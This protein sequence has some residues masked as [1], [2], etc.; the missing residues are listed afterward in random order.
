M[1]MVVSRGVG[2]RTA[3]ALCFAVALLGLGALA[4]WYLHLRFLIQLVPGTV[5][6]QFNTALAFAFLGGA[7]ASLASGRF[8]KWPVVVG[9]SVVAAIG[10]AVI[11]QHLIESPAI[12]TLFFEPWDWDPTLNPA[13]GRTSFAAAMGF[14]LAGIGLCYRAL[15]ADRGF[16]LGIIAAPPLAMAISSLLGQLVGVETL[17]LPMLQ[18]TPLM[19]VNTS[20]ALVLWSLAMM[21][22]AW[23]ERPEVWIPWAASFGYLAFAVAVEILEASSTFLIQLLRFGMLAGGVA[24]V[25]FATLYF[26]ELREGRRRALSQVRLQDELLGTVAHDVKGPLSAVTMAFSLLRDADIVRDPAQ[27]EK[28]I[29][30]AQRSLAKIEKLVGELLDRERLAAGFVTLVPEPCEAADLVDQAIEAVQGIAAQKNQTIIS[31][32]PEELTVLADPLRSY[33]VLLNLLGNAVKFS[34]DMTRIEVTAA[35]EKGEVLFS[36]MDQGPGISPEH[37]ALIFDRFHR[38]EDDGDGPPEQGRR[39]GAKPGH[40]LGLTI[41]R[42]LVDRQGGRIWVESEPGN[43]SRFC[44]T[45]PVPSTR[46]SGVA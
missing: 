33:Q 3:L 10:L 31:A 36:I 13:P 32:V 20:T 17:D 11:A 25:Y 39:D 18:P 34:P 30:A 29:G 28:V 38:V 9:G 42:N 19:A 14:A 22:L 4:G 16:I 45:L 5:P 21:R 15:R 12:D 8:G 24:V 35:V 7:S 23:H 6:M 44:F 26:R 46:P 27:A 43:G 37:H 41:C 40:G 2:D 1:R